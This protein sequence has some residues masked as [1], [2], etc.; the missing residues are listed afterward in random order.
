MRNLCLSILLSALALV[1]PAHAQQPV[2]V[3]TT[4][5]VL[6]DIT[7]NIAGEHAEVV[8]VTKLGA[9]IHGYQPTPRDILRTSDA[10]LIIQ[11]GLNLE[12][13][14]ERFYRRI[15]DV[16]NVV[17]SAGIDPIPLDPQN[18]DK[19]MNPHGW[20]SLRNA[21]I[22]ID[23]ITQALSEIDPNNAQN[24]QINAAA[25]KIQIKEALGPSQSIFADLPL[26][27]KWLT[28][29]EGAFSYLARDLGLNELYLWPVNA[30]QTAL[31]QQIKHVV[32]TVRKEDI[33]VIFCES[34]V[35][36]KPAQQVARETGAAF[37]GT[38]YVDSLSAKDGP[39]PRYI[40]LLTVT[41]GTI[42]QGMKTALER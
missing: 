11:N 5:T 19:G 25:Y 37:G 33:P 40:D 10:D 23:N 12:A 30:D 2:K 26:N 39:V 15:Q 38:L 22:Y 4:F 18:P 8:S 21:D 1:G 7:R 20:M 42:T 28:T 29:C 17:A 35:N 24:Y 9:E 13:W 32:D 14:F 41:I 36:D 3:V 16:P 31:P 27:Q 34:T 6:A